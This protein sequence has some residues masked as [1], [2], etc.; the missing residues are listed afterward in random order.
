MIIPTLCVGMP[1]WT[2]RVH[3][4]AERHRMRYHAERGNDQQGNA[5]P[6]RSCRRLRSLDVSPCGTGLLQ[7]MSRLSLSLSSEKQ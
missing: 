7:S 2:L 1:P 3:C 6:C 4:D 5:D